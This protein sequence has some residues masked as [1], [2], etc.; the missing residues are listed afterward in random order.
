M[1]SHIVMHLTLCSAAARMKNQSSLPV[2]V[3]VVDKIDRRLVDK[4]VRVATSGAADSAAE[5]DI[6]WG[7]Y[8][9]HASVRAGAVQCSGSQ[10]FS[11]IADHNRQLNMKLQNSIAGMPVPVIIQGDVPAEYSYTQ[12]EV[13]LFGKD[14]K[15][16]AAIG[17]PIDASID[18]EDDDQAFYASVYPTNSLM[19][20]APV[21]P[22]LKLKDSVGGYHYVKVP[23]DFIEFRTRRPGLAE[24]DIK[25]E[26]I[27]FI[28][29][30]PEDTLLCLR[31]YETTT[32]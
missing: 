25:D 20:S 31:T 9:A 5:F 29:D 27:Q 17:S 4:T 2:H 8:Q 15:C 16:G 32:H 26:L 21:T 11:V 30:K 1:L 3:V 22:A 23:N 18:Q 28:A 24:L 13:V 19:Q 7:V 14:T 6:A 10:F 12:P